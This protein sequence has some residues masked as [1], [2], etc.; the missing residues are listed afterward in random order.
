MGGLVRK[1]LK[2]RVETE[3][4][5]GIFILEIRNTYQYRAFIVNPNAVQANIG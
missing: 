4:V 2:T 5:N 3:M 1:R